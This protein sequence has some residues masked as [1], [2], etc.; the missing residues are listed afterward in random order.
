MAPL[1]GSITEIRKRWSKNTKLYCLSLYYKSP[2][3]YRFLRNTFS[4][5]SVRTLQII[6]DKF[7]IDCGFSADRLSVLKKRVCIMS[8]KDILCNVCI[9]EM[10]L[11]CGLHYNVSKDRIARFVNM[12][13]SSTM[14]FIHI[15]EYEYMNNYVQYIIL[16]TRIRIFSSKLCSYTAT[17]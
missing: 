17:S 10:S 9:D 8:E 12:D 6:C 16:H 11:N 7:Q 15:N 5:P 1:V 14:R 13:C 4:I 2:S 3:A